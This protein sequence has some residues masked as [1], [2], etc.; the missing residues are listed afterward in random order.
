MASLINRLVVFVYCLSIGDILRYSFYGALFFGAICRTYD[1]HRRLRK[2]LAAALMGWFA[3]AMWITLFSR[4]PGDTAASCWIPLYSYRIYSSGE[5]PELLRSCI[6]NVA[7]FFPAG[8]ILTELLP[9][10]IPFRRRLACSILCFGA[11]SLLIEL[12]QY[13]F[14][15]GNSEFDDVF[16]NTLGAMLGSLSSRLPNPIPRKR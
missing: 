8:L 10:R 2:G 15:L 14:R 12:S 3:L 6:M 1:G 13:C 5:N 7:L 9:R 11:F 4:S 16:H